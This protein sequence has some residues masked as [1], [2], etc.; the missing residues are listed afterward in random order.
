IASRRAWVAVSRTCVAL[1]CSITVSNCWEAALSCWDSSAGVGLACAAGP[2]G[3]R[4]P[5]ART[6]TAAAAAVLAAAAAAR[7]A[8][9][10][11]RG[12]REAGTTGTTSHLRSR[13]RPAD[14]PGG[15]YAL[16]TGY[17]ADKEALLG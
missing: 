5:A 16:V 11:S 2:G 4:P 6:A 10:A 3:K 12:H 8:R 17:A 7:A 15:Y 1:Y 13:M 14:T 9:S